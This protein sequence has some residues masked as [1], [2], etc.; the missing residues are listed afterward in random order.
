MADAIDIAEYPWL[1]PVWTRVAA[2]R[3]A[4][5]HGLLISGV[6]GVAKLEFAVALAKLLLCSQPQTQSCDACRNCT[7]FEA[8]THP[9]FHML[10]TESEAR[11]GRNKLV[12]QYCNRYQDIAAR[13]KRAHPARVIPVDQVRRLIERFNMH[14]HIARR[15]VALI[16]PADR[17]NANAA[18]ALLKLLEEPPGDATLILVSATPG[19]LPATVRSRCLQIALPAPA[20]TAARAWLQ[21]H[22]PDTAPPAAVAD[23]LLGLGGPLD[24]REMLRNDFLPAQTQLLQH[25]ADLA[26]GKLPPLECAAKFGKHDFAALL[27]WLHRFSVAL[28]K[29]ECGDAQPLYE[30]ID[31]RGRKLSADKMFMLYDKIGVYRKIA[32]DPINEQLALEEL[33]FALQRL[34]TAA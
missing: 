25:I 8:A 1:Q 24:A 2:D 30:K 7:L 6:S 9:D 3:D 23:E 32:R 10:T 19:Y 28:I 22:M 13:E 31:L 29:G 11:D 17:M 18:N 34:L 33:A 16:A 15:K 4:L 5:H 21:Q 26:R 14:P 20:A 27:Q 12:A